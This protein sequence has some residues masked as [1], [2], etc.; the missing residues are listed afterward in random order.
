[1]TLEVTTDP[2]FAD[3]MDQGLVGKRDNQENRCGMSQKK[4]QSREG[5]KSS[6]NK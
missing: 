6:G 4:R 2:G 5:E 3:N 1:L